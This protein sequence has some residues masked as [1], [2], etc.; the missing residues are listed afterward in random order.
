MMIPTVDPIVVPLPSL[1][2][3]QFCV[4]GLARGHRSALAQNSLLMYPLRFPSFGLVVGLVCPRHIVDWPQCVCAAVAASLPGF[5]RWRYFVDMW[6]AEGHTARWPWLCVCC[7]FIAS[8]CGCRPASGM[9]TPSRCR[10]WCTAGVNG[11]ATVLGTMVLRGCVCGN[12]GRRAH[13]G[14]PSGSGR[15]G[16]GCS[17]RSYPLV[18]LCR[19]GVRH[20]DRRVGAAW[21]HTPVVH[22]DPDR[23][24]N[25]SA[26]SL[27]GPSPILRCWFS[28]G[29]PLIAAEPLSWVSPCLTSCCLCRGV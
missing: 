12:R 15:L 19:C 14:Y 16:D 26:F 9:H 23:R 7:L 27:T 17:Y 10:A 20:C 5:A 21:R 22:D 8:R 29:T 24:P 4:A 11:V 1:G 18:Y 6:V 13:N 2:H 3:R 25:R 28:K